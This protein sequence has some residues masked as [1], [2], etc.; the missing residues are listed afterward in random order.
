V[1]LIFSINTDG[2]WNK[3]IL[4]LDDNII[5][6]ARN[7]N[8]LESNNNKQ[9]FDEWETQMRNTPGLNVVQIERFI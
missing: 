4:D 6:E 3:F 5:F 9:Y 7:L 1:K 2:T 8:L